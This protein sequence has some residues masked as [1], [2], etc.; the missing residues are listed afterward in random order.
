MSWFKHQFAEWPSKRGW[1][2]SPEGMDKPVLETATVSSRENEWG[3]E[4]GEVRAV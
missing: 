1:K 3:G 4:G 2:H